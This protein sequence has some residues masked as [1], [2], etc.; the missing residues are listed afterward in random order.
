M[1]PF[2]QV[3]VVITVEAS[4]SA[5]SLGCGR[6]TCALRKS[7]MGS[8]VSNSDSSSANK[9]RIMAIF[10]DKPDVAVW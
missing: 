7:I 3:F 10:Y 6:G 4:S 2:L 9:P 5:Q 1:P 8:L